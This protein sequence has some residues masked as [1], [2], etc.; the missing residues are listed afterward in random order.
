M[1]EAFLPNGAER[2]SCNELVP[3]FGVFMP[4][5]SGENIGVGALDPGTGGPSGVMEYTTMRAKEAMI[6]LRRH[7]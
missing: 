4:E 2:Y 7:L 3:I 6:N 5:G 1:D